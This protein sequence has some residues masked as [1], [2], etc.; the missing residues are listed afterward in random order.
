MIKVTF[1]GQALYH[2]HNEALIDADDFHVQG[3][4]AVFSKAIQRPV[5][6][7]SAPW[8]DYEFV[9]A[10]PVERIYSAVRVQ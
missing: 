9:E 3:T 4:M 10:I 2:G 7:G 1:Y 5:E 8:P 6:P